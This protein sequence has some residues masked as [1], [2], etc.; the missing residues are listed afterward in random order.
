MEKK[1]GIVIL[2]YLNYKDTIECVESISI[3]DYSNLEVFIVENGSSNAS[4]EELFKLVKETKNIHIF[5]NNEN[6]GFARGNNVGIKKALEYGCKNVLVVNNDTIF[7]DEKM[8]NKLI[9]EAV[10]T[11]A[12]VIGPKI[13]NRYY[14]E[15]NLISGDD[16][17][18][19]I[20]KDLWFQM[21]SL[22]LVIIIRPVIVNFLRKAKRIFKIY[23]DN[24]SIQHQKKKVKIKSQRNIIL[25]GSALFF[26]DEF[27]KKFKYGFFEKTFLYYEENIL[28]I[29]LRK[30][31][32][33]TYYT[34]NTSIYHKEDMSSEMSF[35]NEPVIKKIYLINSIIKSIY[36]KVI[37]LRFL[38]IFRGE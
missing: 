10:K 12:G 15:N 33:S 36:V 28:F 8:I 9:Q 5:R 14:S 7:N 17:F 1:V 6:L 26:T 20:L 25:H 29:L 19:K 16:S 38:K 22:L 34:D 37:P 2:N 30:A 3:L 21:Y 32:I 35:R 18:K 24:R 13:F 4:Y 27:F 23:S 11:K 31:N